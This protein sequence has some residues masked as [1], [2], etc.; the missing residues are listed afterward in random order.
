MRTKLLCTTEYM[1]QHVCV[2]V[3]SAWL[4]TAPANLRKC[5]CKKLFA[6]KLL[7]LAELIEDRSRQRHPAHFKMVKAI[8]MIFNFV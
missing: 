2:C 7:K 1:H 8:F 3:L 4:R 5:A 6:C